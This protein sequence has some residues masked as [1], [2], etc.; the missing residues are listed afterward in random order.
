MPRSLPTPYPDELAGSVLMRGI[1]RCAL[2]QKR[3]LKEIFGKRMSNLSF[4]LPANI[5]C[6]ANAMRISPER[7]LWGH[8]IFPYAVSH[9]SVAA[10]H[11]QANRSL[12]RWGTNGADARCSAALVQAATQGV[13]SLRYCQQCVASDIRRFGESYWHRAHTLPGVYVCHKHG[14]ALCESDISLVQAARSY[15]CDIPQYQSSAPNQ[16]PEV[17]ASVLQGLAVL[18]AS[19]VRRRQDWHDDWQP[20]YQLFA[21]A[22]GFSAKWGEVASSQVAKHLEAMYGNDF[23]RRLGCQ[24]D[25]PS[26]SWPALMVRPGTVGPFS[27]LKHVLLRTFFAHATHGPKTFSYRPSGKIPRDYASLDVQLA[28]GVSE[29]VAAAERVGR[30]TTVTEVMT[31]L[32][33]WSTYRHDRSKFPLTTAALLRFRSSESSERKLGRRPRRKAGGADTATSKVSNPSLRG[34]RHST[35]RETPSPTCAP[36]TDDA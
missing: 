16:L 11:E 33:R 30:L 7:L 27:P 4:F 20:Q 9:I 29:L 13:Q 5:S 18:S 26:H 15:E 31:S 32:G 19:L 1:I 21:Y 24:V 3:F 14:L 8:T 6:L 22:T 12:A 2:P 23:L 34:E 28:E 17:P 25:R 10:A 36:A 35:S